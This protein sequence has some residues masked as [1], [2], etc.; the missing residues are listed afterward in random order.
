MNTQAV[1]S[2][3]A[4]ALCLCF[5][6]A[7]A[8]TYKI[9]FLGEGKFH[10]E[11][12]SSIPKAITDGW[13]IENFITKADAS[14]KDVVKEK[15]MSALETLDAVVVHP[16]APQFLADASCADGWKAFVERGGA[17]VVTDCNYTDKFYWTDIL[18]PDYRHPDFEGFKGWYP[19]WVKKFP[20]EPTV[21]TF[22]SAQ[23][24]GGILWYHF[25][26]K[27][28]GKAWKPL[29]KCGRHNQPC[30]IMAHYGK[31]LVYL[32]NLRTPYFS[33]LENIRA[34]S[35]LHRAGLE[36]VAHNA[37]CALTN[38][39]VAAEFAVAAEKGGKLTPADWTA[40]LTVTPAEGT[41][42]EL[43][44]KG[45]AAGS[46]MAFKVK[47][48]N[49]V[50]G[51]GCVRLVL[52]N[53][54]AEG[55]ITLIDRRQTFAPLVEPV[56]PRYR[57]RVSTKRREPNV[58][59]GFR[60]NP[61]DE[62]IAGG[63]WKATVTDKDGRTVWYEA[64]KLA[65]G[66][67][68]HALDAKIPPKTPAGD[69]TLT[70][71]VTSAATMK[72]HEASAV[73]HIVAPT[74][75]QVMVDQDGFLIRGGEP[76]FPFGMYGGKPSAWKEIQALGIDLQHS[77]NWHDGAYPS[78]SEAGQ[79]LLY[80]NKHRSPDNLKR[81]VSK[82]GAMPCAR[83]HY[84]VDEPNDDLVWKWEAC[85]RA[86]A[87]GDPEHPTYAVLL[88]PAS[89]RYQS[90][91]ADVL[92][93]DAYP[94]GQGGQGNVAAVSERI[95]QMR[96]AIGDE[97]PVLSV[98]Q[99][100]GHEPPRKFREMAYLSVIHGAKGLM[101]FAWEW[102]DGGMATSTELQGTLKQLIEELKPALP[103]L[104]STAK[105]TVTISKD[106]KRHSAVFGDKATGRYE[107]SVDLGAKEDATKIVMLGA[108]GKGK[109][110]LK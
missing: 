103:A 94:I 66:E 16:L 97:K 1:K 57:A 2:L 82:I 6:S 76:W 90:G 96:S 18:G 86:M 58:R 27:N 75:S 37:G 69:Y 14:D 10:F 29:L 68:S 49:R 34:A 48:Y 55:E 99:A 26:T 95:D 80:E 56:L 105:P 45:E 73:F 72:K 64:G 109:K 53:A 46:G 108:S 22:P 9:G 35:E 52:K 65:K 32:T 71:A 7:F 85:N 40:T 87:E 23:V 84:V 15:L 8:G 98:M 12:F 77:M 93:V 74:P 107:I 25:V 89:V 60:I 101:W 50:R 62:K 81:W 30:A 5:A 106:G 41:P 100:F 44:A 13:A 38:A 63:R 4:L 42:C 70:V 21:R 31:G 102:G 110:A 24:D 17:V 67:T 19:A 83:M 91:I 88:Y 47:G 20:T 3:S 11:E 61:A 39:Q 54:K 92:A 33:F 51:E 104:T 43:S 59:L 36:L 28:A 78:L 79:G